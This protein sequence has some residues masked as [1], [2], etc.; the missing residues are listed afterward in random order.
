[1]HQAI[2]LAPK[3]KPNLSSKNRCIYCE[4]TGHQLGDSGVFQRDCLRPTREQ[5]VRQPLS[6]CSPA[7]LPSD[8]MDENESEDERFDGYDMRRGAQGGNTGG[9]GGGQ[10]A[11]GGNVA[12]GDNSCDS[13]SSS[14][15]SHWSNASSPNLRDFLGS[16]KRHWSR[17]NKDKYDRR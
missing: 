11:R 15:D 9:A 8:Q 16:C 5:S 13:S 4:S 17:D 6:L 12:G 14:S 2:I 1:M 10:P 3:E 7:H